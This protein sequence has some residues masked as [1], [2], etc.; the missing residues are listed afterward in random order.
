MTREDKLFKHLLKN[1]WIKKS[2]K[3]DFYEKDCFFKNATRIDINGDD[4]Y[5]IYKCNV[6]ICENCF[7]KVDNYSLMVYKF[8][9]L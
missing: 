9:E 8:I 3:L 6:I 7:I 2:A 5:S 4:T 1:G